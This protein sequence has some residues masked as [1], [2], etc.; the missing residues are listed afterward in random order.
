MIIRLSL[1]QQKTLLEW[2]GKI[3][4]AHF[5]EDC[6]PPGY[7]LIVLVSVLGTIAEARVDSQT[8][9]L[10]EVEVVVE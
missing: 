7:E 2:S 8:L 1:A 4:S 3:N 9:D 5:E 10:G 6:L